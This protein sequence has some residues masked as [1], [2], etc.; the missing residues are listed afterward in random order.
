MHTQTKRELKGQQAKPAAADPP[1]TNA[2]SGWAWSCCKWS[3]TNQQLL[4]P[5]KGGCSVCKA[6]KCCS[7]A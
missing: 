1:P 2:T 5:T 4:S 6:V 7:W 3:T